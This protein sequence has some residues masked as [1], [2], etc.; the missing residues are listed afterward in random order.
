MAPSTPPPGV[1]VSG[2]ESTAAWARRIERAMSDLARQG[3]ASPTALSPAALDGLARYLVLVDTWNGRHDLTAARDADELV[4]LF[5]ADAAVIAHAEA[6]E[7]TPEAQR[8]TWVDV[9]SGAGAPGLPLALLRQDAAL[10]LVEP[11][12]KRVAFLRTVIGTLDLAVDV[13]RARSEELGP[14]SFDV[15]ISRATL[16]PEEW[17]GEGCRIA[18]RSVWLL[19]AQAEPP[20][21]PGWRAELDLRYR[22]PLSGAE[23]RALRLVRSG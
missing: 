11:R 5:V 9:G 10:T 18:R 19:L 1:A 22:W 20:P 4:D 23:R 3:A 15:A 13:R 12:T 6:A 2:A 8:S 21:S 7:A 17:V 16:P 14:T